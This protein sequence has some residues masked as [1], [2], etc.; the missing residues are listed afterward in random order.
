MLFKSLS[1]KLYSQIELSNSIRFPDIFKGKCVYKVYMVVKP[2][3]GWFAQNSLNP[4]LPSISL[5]WYKSITF[6]KLL[7][8]SSYSNMW[9]IQGNNSYYQTFSESVLQF[10]I[11][12]YTNTNRGKKIIYELICMN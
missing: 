7:E 10:I 12:I 8:I 6:D 2:Y 3:Q 11:I 4:L 1:Y 9:K 5:L